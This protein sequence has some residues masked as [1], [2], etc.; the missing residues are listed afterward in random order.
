[1]APQGGG[2]AFGLRGTLGTISIIMSVTDRATA[3]FRKMAETT[4]AWGDRMMATANKIRTMGIALTAVGATFTAIFSE[5]EKVA[6]PVE[7]SLA[8]LTALAG[9]T[10]RSF[11][12]W[13]SITTRLSKEFIIMPEKAASALYHIRSAGVASEEQILAVAD[14][15]FKMATI[16]GIDVVEGTELA[17]T[18]AKAFGIELEGIE[19]VTN[20]FNAAISE[21]LL[22]LDQLKESFKYVGPVAATAGIELES[23]TAF[24]MTVADAGI[25]GS[26]AGRALRTSIVRLA[27][28]TAAARRVIAE[29]GLEFFVLTEK[30]EG[31]R[32]ELDRTINT[33][34]NLEDQTAKAEDRIKALS[35]A[36]EDLSVREKEGRLMIERIRYRAA[37]EGRELDSDEMER[38]EKMELHLEGLGL[39]RE[40]LALQEM[41]EQRVKSGLIDQTEVAQEREEELAKQLE[42]ERVAMKEIAEIVRELGIAMLDLGMAERLA[43]VD[44]LVGKRA[45]DTMMAALKAEVPELGFTQ[46]MINM[47]SVASDEFT[48]ETGKTTDSLS[49]LTAI[50]R[51]QGITGTKTGEMYTTAAE[52]LVWNR[53]Q[54]EKSIMTLNIALGEEREAM[55]TSL[56]KL[57]EFKM[58]FAGTIASLSRFEIAGYSVVSMI[59]IAGPALVGL[60]MIIY[61]VG[62]AGRGLNWILVKTHIRMAAVNAQ[63]T[64]Q[65]TLFGGLVARQGAAAASTWTL[66]GAF[67]ALGHSIKLNI[68]R[69]LAWIAGVRLGRASTLF[70]VKAMAVRLAGA[71]VGFIKTIGSAIYWIGRLI[72]TNF[73]AAA[74]SIAHAVAAIAARHA[75][76]LGIGAVALAA[77]A[78]GALILVIN[79]GTNAM[80]RQGETAK[81]VAGTSI[82]LDSIKGMVRGANP[83]LEGMTAQINAV[84][85]AGYE[86]AKGIKAMEIA[87]DRMGA[88]SPLDIVAPE[89]VTP[90]PEEG[91]ISIGEI[92]VSV[93]TGPITGVADVEEVG[94]LISDR[95]IKRI[96][97]SR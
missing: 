49:Y 37:R 7:K 93:T 34:I 51:E 73:A 25:K 44:T 52:G 20:V 79:E 91:G 5:M 33:I 16:H 8:R 72:A 78:L 24:L 26:R 18:A 71:F 41:K 12:D 94:D 48:E 87:Y 40:T 32:T 50:L 42:L 57:E 69:L 38:I 56:V 58:M 82:V 14:A 11:E 66:T 90:T 15:A 45:I 65:T 35:D 46:D 92:S 39:Q 68:K 61:S 62:I 1:M 64:A 97:Q 81:K 28:P 22:T 67:T 6:I 23:V 75:W 89:E 85:E 77:A 55:A 63:A 74:A 21:S 13:W 83:L 54:V 47:L 86:S 9:S 43:A 70:L 10:G 29:L 3:K 84:G 53:A 2:G 80:K 76:L 27:A 96:R 31:I 60:A 59:S 88:I 30:G 95:I 4:H 17:L 19:R 36:M